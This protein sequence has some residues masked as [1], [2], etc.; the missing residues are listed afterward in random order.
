MKLASLQE[1][2]KQVLKPWRRLTKPQQDDVLSAWK[3]MDRMTY[4][5]NQEADNGV[6]RWPKPDEM[7]KITSKL[8]PEGKQVFSNYFDVMNA[9]IDNWLDVL[10]EDA[11][12]KGTL[13][14]ISQRLQEIDKLAGRMHAAPYVPHARFGDYTYTVYDRASGEPVF[15]SRSESAKERDAI[16]RDHDRVGQYDPK[17]FRSTIG[18]LKEDTRS[19]AGI[20]KYML[21][22]VGDKLKGQLSTS[23]KD[24]ISKMQYEQSPARKQL[25]RWASRSTIP[26]YSDD[27]MR[28][29]ADHFIHSSNYMARVRFADELQAQ[30]HEL[31][32][33]LP[34]LANGT[35]LGMVRN[36][37]ASHFADWV[38]PKSDA[39]KIKAAAFF[40]YLGFNPKSALVNLTQ[41]PLQT[42]PFLA[43]HFG[44][45]VSIRELTRQAMNYTN[46]YKSASFE[47]RTEFMFR[48]QNEL[49]KAGSTSEALAPEIASTAEDRNMVAKYAGNR[50]QRMWSGFLHASG[51][52]FQMTE[53]ANRRLAAAAAGQLALD[54]PN[55]KGVIDA[56]RLNPDFYTSLVNSGIDQMEARAITYAKH[57]VEQTQGTYARWAR[58]KIFQGKW[59]T[60]FIFKSFQQQFLSM[61]MNYPQTVLRST[62]VMGAMGGMLGLPGMGDAEDLIKTLAYKVFGADFDLERE[63]RQFII[64]T[65]S[66]TIPPDLLLHGVSRYGWGIPELLD[67][68]GNT[69]HLGDVPFPVTDISS[70]VGMGQ[71]SPVQL[72]PLFDA[73]AINHPDAAAGNALSQASGAAFSMAYSL[74]RLIDDPTNKKV[75]QT[76]LPR[77]AVNLWR[78]W[79]AYH[80]NIT[81]PGGAHVIRFD[82]QDTREMME[83]AAMAFGYN[84]LRLEGQWDRIR[85]M[86]EVESLWQLR[87]T[88][89]VRQFTDSIVRKDQEDR[90]R[91]LNSIRQ[92]NRT[93]PIELAAQKIKPSDLESSVKSRLKTNVLQERGLA[94]SPR[95]MGITK[96]MNKLYPEA[97][98]PSYPKPKITIADPFATLPPEGQVVS[99][100]SAERGTIL[101]Q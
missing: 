45:A 97:E 54:H 32:M 66:G 68:V 69:M 36:R 17:L 78:A 31:D 87:R 74:Y 88:S 81:T 77:A 52:L 73:D 71:I 37:M 48:L 29:F 90:S 72:Y 14:E 55:A 11:Q 28:A 53:S 4:R 33:Q 91:V 12:K 6:L 24:F 7:D 98:M 8:T 20:P 15:F 44:D 100:K 82:P 21:G 58:P 43:Q 27:F 60:T 26:G 84:P 70:S 34:T 96:Q 49:Q 76:L 23:Q 18:V 9:D 63:A 47:G 75:W 22:M 99:Q 62:L 80:D 101:S 89:L 85:A 19:L 95:N 42:F 46:F 65:T 56:V 79:D 30:I 39:W 59:G 51:F 35:K 25:L 41:T 86:K 3:E 64:D 93:V 61:L 5:S 50:S 83:A 13:G 2:L 92:F 40:I 67:L 94:P 57:A 1:P 16:K 38:D 10:R